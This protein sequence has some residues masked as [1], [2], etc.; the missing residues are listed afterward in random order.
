MQ[1]KLKKEEEFF[2]KKKIEESYQLIEKATKKMEFILAHQEKYEVSP[3]KVEKLQM[4]YEKILQFK[5]TTNI[6]KLQEIGELAL[7]KI[8]E[9]ELESLDKN[10]NKETR[11]LL[12]ETNTLLRKIGSTQ[13]FT[14]SNKDLK[15]M[16]LHFLSRVQ[17]KRNKKSVDIEIE[18]RKKEIGEIDKNSYD[19][20]NTI[21]RIEKYEEKE[22]QVKKEL[23]QGYF[24]TSKENREKL[25]V[26]LQVIRQ[27][28]ALLKAKK[29][30][31]I[32]SYT[33]IKKGLLKWQETIR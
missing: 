7:I 22:K 32:G 8:G 14:E 24:K 1:D 19:Y 9:I 11:K 16:F 6:A 29:E 17:E 23:L 3:E 33:K 31:G 15:K 10:K 25:N 4:I 13:H 5:K 26:R 2:L 27:N 30:G 21:L 20:L 12:S 18:R 28:I